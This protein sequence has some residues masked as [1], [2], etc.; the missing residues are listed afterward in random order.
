MTTED[1]RRVYAEEY[2]KE[3]FS[4]ITDQFGQK[5]VIIPALSKLVDVTLNSEDPRYESFRYLGEGARFFAIRWIITSTFP[6][7]DVE[8]LTG[9]N[10]KCQDAGRISKIIFDQIQLKKALG[11]PAH[12]KLL[13]MY[14]GVLVEN[15]GMAAVRGFIEP[16]IQQMLTGEGTKAKKIGFKPVIGV[17]P[18]QQLREAIAISGGN[19]QI[20]TAESPDKQWQATVM[21]QLI[22]SGT[23]FTHTRIG[24]SKQKA[25]SAACFDIL[26]FLHTH[27]DVLTH[28][29]NPNSD[30]S[31]A[32][33]L[34]INTED[35]CNIAISNITPKPLI[36]FAN[37]G[38]QNHPN[39]SNWAQIPHSDDQEETLRQLSLLLLG[40]SDT[41]TQSQL[42]SLRAGQ[43]D[44]NSSLCKTTLSQLPTQ[45]STAFGF[46]KQEMDN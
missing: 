31:Q 2:L 10:K 11:I 18:K 32:H 19:I 12:T 21:C 13:D 26:Q 45:S 30:I 9:H 29:L 42:Q 41:N 22:Q 39:K 15:F 36:N 8:T 6:N 46:I 17:D 37:T 14:L 4:N 16:A 28:L 38:T 20:E 3:V 33:P 23:I 24:P 43:L 5:L 1:Q 40:N 27:S 35:Y 25:S 34:P 44:A 7:S